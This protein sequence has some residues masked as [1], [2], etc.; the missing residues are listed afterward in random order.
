MQI[1]HDELGW[2]CWGAVLRA[3]GQMQK[4]HRDFQQGQRLTRE[5]QREQQ[6][7]NVAACAGMW[8]NDAAPER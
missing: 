3:G 6:Q 4:V 8:G 7:V 2:P 5:Q 1:C